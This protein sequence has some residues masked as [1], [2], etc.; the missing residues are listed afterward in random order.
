MHDHIESK[1]FILFSKWKDKEADRQVV[2]GEM[3]E[4]GTI[5]QYENKV[6]C[7]TQNIQ[8]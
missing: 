3:K 2:Q 4:R 8:I 6:A 5:R 7:K 1:E